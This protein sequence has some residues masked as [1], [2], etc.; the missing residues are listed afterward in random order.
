MQLRV[1]L[2]DCE[3]INVIFGIREYFFLHY[4]FS[5]IKRSFVD[6]ELLR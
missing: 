5:S 6:F 3:S 4:A 1:V 2:R